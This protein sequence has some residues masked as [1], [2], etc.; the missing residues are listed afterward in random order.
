MWKALS[1]LALFALVAGCVQ[2]GTG[3][4]RPDLKDD[5]VEKV[6]IGQ[7]ESEVTTLLGNPW[8]R[9]RFDNLKST[10]MDYRYRDTWGYWVDF[11]VMVGD[12]GKVV[13]KVSQRIDPVL[14]KD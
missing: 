8:R 9:V 13:G 12:D 2:S 6:A 5:I 3:L 7:S 11:S 14:G 1:S 4:Y 10:A